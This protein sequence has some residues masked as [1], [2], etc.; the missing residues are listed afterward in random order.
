MQAYGLT[1]CV[2]PQVIPSVGSVGA[3]VAHESGLLL[4]LLRVVAPNVGCEASFS[5]ES[6]VANVADKRLFAGVYPAMLVMSAFECGNVWTLG[7][8]TATLSLGVGHP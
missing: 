4:C 3:R 2:C 6:T 8:C 7:A 5:G 1:P